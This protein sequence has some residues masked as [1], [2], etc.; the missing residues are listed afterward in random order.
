M[1]RGLTSAKTNVAGFSLLCLAFCVPISARADWWSD[2]G[3][4]IE[5]TVQH[6]GDAGADIVTLGENGRR[7][8]RERAEAEQKRVE[9]QKLAAER[10][11][12]A[13]IQ[14]LNSQIVLVDSFVANSEANITL[15][16][17]IVEFDKHLQPLAQNELS[18]RARIS[19]NIEKVSDS[20]RKTQNDI[21]KL[22]NVLA[23]MNIDDHALVKAASSTQGQ[24]VDAAAADRRVAEALAQHLQKT[25]RLQSD[26]TKL[27]IDAIVAELKTSD[28]K[29][30]L[31]TT[32][33]S[34]VNV[35]AL[36]AHLVNDKSGYA[37]KAAG[38]R[39]QLAELGPI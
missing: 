3:H 30:L 12:S 21:Q 13:K 16:D 6:A 20:H 23:S 36:R 35:A 18:R 34:A 19:A 39:K 28:L 25:A 8:D 22:A 26:T 24:I 37:S 32:T 1:G 7:R 33:K 2:R 17:Q 31:E 4:E 15:A 9:D 14:D 5:H 27:G 38:L 10:E 29:A 11:K